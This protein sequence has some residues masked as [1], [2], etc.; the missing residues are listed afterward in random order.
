VKK[1]LIVEQ[2]Q[3]PFRDP[4]KVDAVVG[5]KRKSIADW[6]HADLSQCPLA[7]AYPDFDDFFEEIHKQRMEQ[8]AGGKLAHPRAIKP[9]KG[10]QA[11][12]RKFKEMAPWEDGPS[13]AD[14][15]KAYKTT[16]RGR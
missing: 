4:N 12:K 16:H 2:L 7:K 13:A 14:V 3:L 5:R 6:D 15:N 9:L 10:L 1:T 11:K 8:K